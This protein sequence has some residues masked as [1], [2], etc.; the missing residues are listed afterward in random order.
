MDIDKESLRNFTELE[1]IC[2]C[3]HEMTY[4]SFDQDDIADEFSRIKN[5]ADEVKNMSEEEKKEKLIPFEEVKKKFK[6]KDKDK[7]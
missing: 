2:H 3:L 6:N 7:S 1:L 4:F 5:V